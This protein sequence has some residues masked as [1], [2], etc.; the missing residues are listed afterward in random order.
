MHITEFGHG[1]V[2][3]IYNAPCPLDVVMTALN[4]IPDLADAIWMR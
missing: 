4:C 2:G 3:D 1:L